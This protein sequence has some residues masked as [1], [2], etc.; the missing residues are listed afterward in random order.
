MGNKDSLILQLYSSASGKYLKF[1]TRL[2]RAVRSGKFRK[3]SRRKQSTL[4]HRLR[5]LYDRL[6][7]LHV[8]LKVA[9]AALGITLMASS[10]S[11]A[12]TL[13]PF[14]RD[15]NNTRNILPPPI[16]IQKSKPVTVDIDND[17]DLDVFVGQNDGQIR[18]FRN[19]APAP[20]Q[21]RRL[22][23]VVGA[24][25]PLGAVNMG[26]EA[27]L[28]FADVDGDLLEDVLI[29]NHAGQT[30]FFRNTGTQS[31][32]VFE[33]KT[34]VDNPFEGLDAIEGGKYG[35]AVPLLV[36]FDSDGDLDLIIGSSTNLGFAA[37]KFFSN[38]GGGFK[39]F[40]NSSN[41]FDGQRFSNAASVATVDIDGDS[42]LDA[43]I[44]SAGGF[45]YFFI[46][47]GTSFDQSANEA[48]D[49]VAKT[50]NPLFEVAAE[51]P[52][53]S[54]PHLADMDGDGD[55][56][57]LIGSYTFSGYGEPI[58]YMEN[59]D[60]QFTFEKREGLNIG[61]FDGVDVG[62]EAFPTFADIDGD[63]DL[64]AVIGAK[65]N[66]GSGI[67]EI[68]VFGNNNGT[69]FA[70][71]EH[72]IVTV[73]SQNGFESIKPVFVD[74]DGDTDMDMFYGDFNRIRFARNNDDIFTDE[75]SPLSEA[76][77]NPINPD[78][79]SVAF[80]DLENN[81]TQDAFVVTHVEGGL[82]KLFYFRNQG[83]ATTPSFVQ[84]TAPAPFNTLTF[85][86]NPNIQAVD[87]D[88][89]GDRDLVIA[90]SVD[91]P[92]DAT[93]FRFF[94]NQGNGTFTEIVAPLASVDERES[95][96][97]FADI[98]GDGDLDIFVGDG[99]HN[100]TIPERRGGQISY[101]ANENPP[102]TIGLDESTTFLTGGTS[103]FVDD[104]LSI[105][106]IDSDMMVRA[107]IFIQ[108][109]QPGDEELTFTS[110]GGVTGGF[111]DQTG[112][113]TLSGLATATTYRD[114]LRS[115]RYQFIGN[116]PDGG[117]RKG[118]NN[119]RTTTFDRT[120]E[121]A[122]ID[123]DLTDHG[124]L[125]QKTVRLT[126]PNEVP[127][128][129]ASIP[130]INFNG[131]PVAIDNALTAIDTDDADL[132]GAV[133]AIVTGFNSAED[134]LLF[135]N[136]NGITGSY[137]AVTGVL[138]LTGTSSVANYQAALRSIR[139]NKPLSGNT[140][141][142]TID[143]TTS[144]SEDTSN[145]ISI[146]VVMANQPPQI[147]FSGVNTF[148]IVGS[149][150][151]TIDGGVAVSDADNSTLQGGTVRISSASFVSG[152]LLL[153]TNQ[154]G[155]SGNYNAATGTLTLTGVASAANYQAALRSIQYNNA[156]A[157]P[158]IQDRI[159][160][161]EISDGVSTNATATKTVHILNNNQP[162][163]IATQNAGTNIGGSV[164]INLTT[165]LSD[166]DNNLDLSTI[167]IG[168]GNSGRTTLGNAPV[169]FDPVTLIIHIDYSGNSF[170]G[171]DELFVRI[172]D[173]GGLSS[174]AIFVIDVSDVITVFNGISIN[175]DQLNQ[176]LL[177]R[178][179]EALAAENKVSIYNRWGSL[180]FD[181]ANY[182]NDT[183]RFEGRN[184]SGDELP[185]G[186][187]F[188]KIEF[189]GNRRTQTGYLTIKR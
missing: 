108:G 115:I 69:F 120:I 102:P 67:P 161:F 145:T 136:Q 127:T 77:I 170:A 23:E 66:F 104:Q 59:V 63:G 73:V 39:E 60:G 177:L 95:A 46:N 24:G 11:Q 2:D 84:V 153:F 130:S 158:N 51:I 22:V 62:D 31:N 181:I 1:K 188:Y 87:F 111:D 12:Q 61:P 184:N 33:Q 121:F 89:D 189:P 94:Q 54:A 125:V 100:Y 37:I 17:G 49:P 185:S 68:F 71:P 64:D 35:P 151:V 93:V 142:R 25:N 85:D 172:F 112:I 146:D 155:I 88:N 150:G 140:Q 144:D 83:D 114:V 176:Y 57:I 157:T 74:I 173:S 109:F 187:Y 139:F 182:N 3:L 21:I 36:D 186:T 137:S 19:D 38:D 159:I 4:L 147:A 91:T 76:L 8:Q 65:Y 15:E 156:S 52:G 167:E 135:T 41:P 180:V 110:Q 116:K 7:S 18:F 45:T 149:G 103:G 152:D 27:A 29:G 30:F 124:P 118:A 183:K 131:T 138:T 163:V 26:N 28:S 98:D 42:D 70:A 129:T 90:E 134:Q 16:L 86:D 179:I 40:L 56:D 143:I 47:N 169:T 119:A 107:I 126:F 9:G 154:N 174:Q 123:A 97:C 43:F 53:H 133:I 99:R 168:V 75:A 178:N 79:I 20:G 10:A 101:F 34:G 171:L 72:S 160:E 92:A 78:E 48:W 14:V 113:L 122:L 166:P 58:L 175:N 6:K 50:G 55:L 80:M 141:T 13:G 132:E 165:L 117:A 44:G 96:I 106:D 105:S 82:S 128:L 81:G 148:F 164:D 32:A 5:K 162:P